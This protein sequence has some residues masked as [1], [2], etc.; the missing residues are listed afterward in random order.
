MVKSHLSVERMYTAETYQCSHQLHAVTRQQ[1]Q[2]FLF[3]IVSPLN[4]V[5]QDSSQH[6]DNGLLSSNILLN[7]QT[8]LLGSNKV[9]D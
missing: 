7:L 2:H 9:I 5:K 1:Y 6:S 4:E 8:P 3:C